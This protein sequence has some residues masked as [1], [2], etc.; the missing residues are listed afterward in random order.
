MQRI[1][2]V[3]NSGSGKTTLA[4]SLAAALN[5]PHLELDAIYHLP[6]WQPRPAEEFRALVEDFITGDAWVVDGNYSK[7]RDL[8][9]RRADTVVWL[10]PPRPAVMRQLMGRTLSRMARRTELWNG[11]RE[12]FVNLF[13]VNPQ[14]S[15]L[16]WA[17][18]QHDKYRDRY[19]A[20]GNDPANAHLTFVR[21]ASRAQAADFARQAASPR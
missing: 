14:E 7:V 15:I 5:V 9:W 10:D 16:R 21:L 6:G 17:W 2:V 3:G 18:T 13:K 11:N 4:A 1:S 12:S 19:A 20:A 8:V